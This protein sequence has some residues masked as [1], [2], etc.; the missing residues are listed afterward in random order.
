MA[1]PDNVRP[2][3]IKRKKNVV[4]DGH[5]GGAW[6]VAY[7]DFVTAMMA[8]FLM[9][10]L[11][12]SVTEEQRK[13]VADYFSPTLSIQS[14]SAGGSNS[15]GGESLSST[16][17]L[18]DDIATAAE[19]EQEWQPL[20]KLADSL[21]ALAAE[22]EAIAKAFEHV[23]IRMSDDGLIVELFDL[24]HA[25]LFDGLT[26]QPRPVLN[27]LLEVVSAAFATVANPVAIAAH[28]RG[29]P[30]VFLD[31]PVWPLSL[32]RASTVH[33]M[34]AASP[35]EDLRFQRVTGQ[36]DRVPAVSDPTAVRNNRIELT[37]LRKI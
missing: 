37:L 9:L 20:E 3:I 7:A 22:D 24:D 15:F 19:Y 35:I 4:G 32:E 36:A 6:K 23:A 30:T 17:S 14:A 21:H 2:I 25:A 11:L 28:T 18:T 26:A 13:G 5:H 12:G 29:F 34:M 16:A 10:W 33:R 1:R 27:L 31:D 8:F